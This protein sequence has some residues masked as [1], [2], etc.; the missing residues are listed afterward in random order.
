MI[1]EDEHDLRFLIAK[2]TIQR[3]GS[4]K[5]KINDQRINTLVS[6]EKTKIYSTAI[7]M[8]RI[9][10]HVFHSNSLQNEQ[11]PNPTWACDICHKFRS[12]FLHIR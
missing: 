8:Y 9:S 4:E 12:S 10:R 1:I 11:L 6:V 2:S 5:V 7:D 3:L